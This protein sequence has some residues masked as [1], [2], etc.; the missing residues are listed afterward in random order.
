LFDEIRYKDV[1]NKNI[2]HRDEKSITPLG[3]KNFAM[4][5]GGL[6]RNSIKFE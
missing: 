5:L 6:R 2:R 1:W 4:E 3:L